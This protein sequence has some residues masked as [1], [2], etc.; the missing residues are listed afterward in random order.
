MVAV[1]YRHMPLTKIL[2]RL[3]SGL[4]LSQQESHNLMSV[5][6]D[7][8]APAEQVAGVLVALQVKGAS[9]AE[10]AGLASLLREKA[11]PLGS[12]AKDL[13]DTCGTGGGQ[14]TFNLSTGAAL[15]A[16]AAGAKVAKH[17][18]RSVTSKCG[19]ADVLEALG[20]QMTADPESLARTL[21]RVGIVFL[22]APNHHGSLKA[23][24][25][26]RRALGVRTVF[27][28]LGPL[29]NP[30]GASRQLIGV[31]AKE[32]VRPMAEALSL[33]GSEHAF[34]VHSDDGLDEISPCAATFFAELTDGQVKEGTFTPADF[35]MEALPSDA[36]EAGTTVEDSAA[37]LRNALSGSDAVL[38][39]ALV[40]NAA[41]ALLL[42]GVV[43]D[44]GKGADLA[45]AAI[46]D[47]APMR[48]LEE[49]IVVS[50]L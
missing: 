38:G 2:S 41:T 4:D 32:L 30:A 6:A 46:G 42:A 40:P 37:I 49:L 10:L 36:L 43:S 21:E 39:A 3:M 18:N 47:G 48:K 16:A 24:G 12:V 27:N 28:Q 50:A 1:H 17:G 31:Y 22:F 11:L 45:R 14:Q 13:V 7:G 29:A 5:L 19:S 15:V 26:V 35:G 23:V 33:L 8:T 25:P 34:V 9:P 44:L 20:L